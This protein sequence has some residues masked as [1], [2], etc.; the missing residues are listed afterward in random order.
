MKG[1]SMID[2]VSDLRG[3]T[4]TQT[5]ADATGHL[6]NS[7]GHMPLECVSPSNAISQCIHGMAGN[8]VAALQTQKEE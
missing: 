6:Q 7:N 5:A 4:H 1:Y 8:G 3:T 2:L